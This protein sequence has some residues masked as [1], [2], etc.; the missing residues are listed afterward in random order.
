M[1]VST[2]LRV[3]SKLSEQAM[4]T[5][6]G[7]NLGR[8]DYDVLLTGPTRVS[9][10]DG[11]PLAIYLP[12]ALTAAMDEP[13]VYEVLHELRHQISRNRGLAS[14]TPRYKSGQTRSYTRPIAS[15]I[16]GAIDPGGQ[17][18][19][20]RLTS[21]TGTHLP[22][23]ETLHP[24]L[25]VIAAH[26]AEHV[27]ERYKAQLAEARRTHPAWV[28]PGTPFTTITVNNC[29]DPA[30]Q[31]LTRRLGWTSY[32]QLR[33]DDEILAYDPATGTTRWERLAGL[34]VNPHHDGEMT[35]LTARGFSALTTPEHRWPLQGPN[36]SRGCKTDLATTVRT[37]ADLPTGYWS[38]LRSAPHEAPAE[39]TYSDAFVRVAAWYFT[40][41]TLL[42][43]G[44]SVSICQS[45][46]HNPHHVDAIRRDLKELGG[47]SLEQWR[48]R[49]GRDRSP[50]NKTMAAYRASRAGRSRRTGLVV[51]EYRKHSGLDVI[52]WVLTGADVAQLIEAVPGKAKVPSMEF[53]TA[54]TADQARLFVE[55]A[56][57]GDGSPEWRSFDQHHPGRM[58]AFMTAA[59]L[60]GYA[61]ALDSTGTHCSLRLPRS[62]STG[63]RVGLR[64]VKRSPQ[65][66]QGVVWCPRV[67]SGH[68]VARR[69]GTVY[70]TGNS[71]ATGT[72]TDKGDLD[73][74]FS[75]LAVYRRGPYTGGV[76]T[77]PQY[78][79]AVD[80]AHGD[81]LLMDAH[82][83]HGNTQLYCGCGKTMNGPCETCAGERISI[84]SYF[85]TR[86]TQCGS[87]DEEY[88]RAI[89]W[90]E[91]AEQIRLARTTRQDTA[92]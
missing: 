52:M 55:T 61:P 51:N 49:P 10:L 17:Q 65:S 59:V 86:L 26:L 42:R 48:N 2:D 85:R 76:F 60:A 73:A 34:F 82:D 20:C 46:R 40:E 78:R 16:V 53:L 83:W 92:S 24:L 57:A 79:L 21:W 62:S 13:G 30:T 15:A 87:P 33:R 7:K 91:H 6:A 45:D 12:G 56:I 84:V 74:G 4:D 81:L 37:T 23:W 25:R 77:F 64:S 11:R 72:H 44:T 9:K 22:E 36:R 50:R 80:M 68:W 70:V 32:D 67:P 71:Y 39:P 35:A 27:P 1:T 41:G 63:A 28:V 89:E 38:I 31:C 43:A 54:L 5:R 88:N 69:A 29:V 19:Y 90:H 47:I 75:T 66:Y 8:A 18:R 58:D 14:A 3:R